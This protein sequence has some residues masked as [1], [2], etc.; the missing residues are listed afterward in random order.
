MVVLDT[1]VWIWWVGGPGCPAVSPAALSAIDA[2]AV[3]GI[4]ATTCVEVAWLAAKGRVR[5]DRD[6]L[7]WLHQAL[8]RPRVT[9]LPTTP[10]IAV[11]AAGLDWTHRDPAD[12]L[13]LATAQV[14]RASLVTADETISRFAS[15]LCVW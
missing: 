5:F 11:V 15:A 3:V 10:E 6:T 2:A 4:S 7:T 8:A 13:I 9:L 1:H 14:H 12:R